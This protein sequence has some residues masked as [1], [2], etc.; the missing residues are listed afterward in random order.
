MKV[1]V[2]LTTIPPRLGKL[3]HVLH[4][5][6]CQACH[7]VW[8]NIPKKYS[9]FPDWDGQVPDFSNFGPKLVVNRDCEDLGPGTK[10]FG[11]A[12][13][14]DPEDLIVYLDDDTIYD[15]RLV[16]NLI[17]WWR[18]DTK[19]AW[20]LSG[21]DFENYFKCHFPRT[22]GVPLDVLEGYGSVLVKAGWIQAALPEFIELRAEATAADDIIISNLLAKQNVRLKTVYVQDCHVG[23]LQQLQHGFESDALHRQTVGGHQENYRNVLKSL[24]FKGKFYYKINPV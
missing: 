24:E 16:T 12:A 22:H 19:S 11:P 13:H 20:G 2:S 18:T 10:F 5:L 17:K 7:E 15:S 14:L 6:V 8:I 23:H 21:F 3:S 9:R 1:V 4:G